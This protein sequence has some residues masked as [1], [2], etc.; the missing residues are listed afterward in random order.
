MM[1]WGVWLIPVILS[2]V[3][4]RLQ[5]RKNEARRQGYP[6]HL[7]TAY[8]QATWLQSLMLIL[9]IG[10]IEDVFWVQGWLF[11]VLAIAVWFLAGLASALI[12]W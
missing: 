7:R 2:F 9:S 11:G 6:S 3:Y 5:A 12:R 1:R 8:R 10:A 4:S